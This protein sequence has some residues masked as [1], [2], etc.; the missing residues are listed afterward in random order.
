MGN[1]TTTCE[2]K[3]LLG[4]FLSIC[5]L[6]QACSDDEASEMVPFT[7]PISLEAQATIQ[8]NSVTWSE[9]ETSEFERYWVLRSEDSLSDELDVTALA[10][11]NIADF[12]SSDTAS[13]FDTNPPRIPVVYYKVLGDLGDRFVVSPTVAVRREVYPINKGT[14]RL[15]IEPVH[16]TLFAKVFNEGI[17]TVFDYGNKEDLGSFGASR[18]NALLSS[19]VYNGRS[20]LYVYERFSPEL[21]IFPVGGQGIERYTFD[22]NVAGVT[23]DGNGRLFVSFEDTDDRL[24]VYERDGFQEIMKFSGN[25]RSSWDLLAMSPPGTATRLLLINAVQAEEFNFNENGDFLSRNTQQVT[26]ASNFNS[27][28]AIHPNGDF[29]VPFSNGLVM[30]QTLN[31]LTILAGTGSNSHAFSPEGTELYIFHDEKF[32]TYDV[33]SFRLKDAFTLSVNNIIGLFVD[34]DDRLLLLVFNTFYNEKWQTV[35]EIIPLP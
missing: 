25:R 32:K 4:C 12:G 27:Q 24:G 8:G 23:S 19:G 1:R 21:A 11:I 6:I 18:T 34:P 22:E 30:D 33:P 17:V 26:G 14:E 3:F 28:I 35:V 13:F 9:L 20:E 2:F 31:S 7:Y 15:V 5:F 10:G 16:N 29:M